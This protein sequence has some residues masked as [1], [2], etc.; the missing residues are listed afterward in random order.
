MFYLELLC[1]FIKEVYPNDP[2][3]N[4]ICRA[5]LADATP[6]TH[7]FAH[8]RWLVKFC[9]ALLP[10]LDCLLWALEY[11]SNVYFRLYSVW[12]PAK[13][14]TH[15]HRRHHHHHCR[16]HPRTRK[17]SITWKC[18]VL[19]CAVTQN[20]RHALVCCSHHVIISWGQQ[21]KKKKKK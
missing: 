9:V 15:R 21:K 18:F 10:T 4:M 19:L 11:N 20:V 13:L 17:S 1:S 6:P 7:R 14:A 3:Q 8:L 2:T 5:T 16:R 12:F